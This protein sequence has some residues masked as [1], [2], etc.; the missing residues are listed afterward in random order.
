MTSTLILY[1]LRALAALLVPVA[2]VVFVKTR[3]SGKLRN[4]F[5]GAAV[6]FI[7]YC[8]IYAVVST[9][10]EVFTD[11]FENMES[12]VARG[13]VHIIFETL[14]IALG[15]LI[16]FKAVVK[17]ESDNGV[18]LMTGVGFSSCL[19]LIGYAL[20]SVVNSVIAVLYMKNPEAKVSVIFEG[21]VNQV[22]D[23]TPLALFY[24]LLIMLF[25]FVLETAVAFIFYRVLRCENRKIWL[26]A[27]L[28]LRIAAYVVMG[29]S[30]VLDMAVIVI[31]FAVVSVIASGAAYSLTKP[32][33]PKK[34]E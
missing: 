14:C 24:D 12:A 2:A 34:E 32:F 21:N 5:D 3:F 8:L 6:Y 15:Y 23:A 26:L 20:P 18:G 1:I 13:S 7:F 22:I 30:S 31:I 10:F 16:W 9:Y 29:L 27:A 17:K 28:V 11:V 4:F 33:V 19:F 25:L